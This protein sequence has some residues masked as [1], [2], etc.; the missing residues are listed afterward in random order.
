MNYFQ[1][2]HNAVQASGD[3]LGCF[4]KDRAKFLSFDTLSKGWEH[5]RAAEAAVKDDP[6]LRFRVRVAQLPIMYTF[7]MHWN[8][9]RKKAETAGA[10]WPMPES[11]EAANEH[12]MKVARKKNMTRLD[13][14]NEGFGAL[15]RA[16]ERA[17]E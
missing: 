5:L 10:D 7:M 4:S 2:T 17:K 3:W 6:E 14:W 1:V 8:E 16:L 11:I 9:M 12:F 15:E 13:E